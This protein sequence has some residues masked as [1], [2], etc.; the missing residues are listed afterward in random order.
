MR[1]SVRKKK[2]ISGR[3]EE[4]NWMKI[5]KRREVEVGKLL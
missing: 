3:K 1:M 5:V 4:K 2:S